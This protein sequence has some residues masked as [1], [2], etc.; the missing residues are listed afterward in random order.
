MKISD[1]VANVLAGST[2]EGNN[3]L[4]PQRQLERNLY[5]SVNKVLLAIGGKWN[6]KVKSHVFKN[7]P[8]DIVEQILLS[9]EYVDQKKEYQ[10]FETPLNIVCKLVS[11]ADISDDESV[12]EPSAGKGRIAIHIGRKHCDCIELNT[13]NRKYLV[14]SGFNVVGEDFLKFDKEY[15]VIIAN[16]PFTKQ[17]D[18]EHVTHMI[19][20]AKRRVVSV[21]SASVLFRDNKKTV[22]FRNLVESFGGTIESLPEETFKESGTNVNTCVVCLDITKQTV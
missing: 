20:L 19:S 16:P 2:I 5:L 7:N 4:L 15:D 13:E 1:N 18:V 12:L 17:Q 6:R 9:G 21:M 8:E 22:D 3:L 10:F 11:L 14:D